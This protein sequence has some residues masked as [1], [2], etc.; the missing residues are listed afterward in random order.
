MLD[1]CAAVLV[2]VA[3]ACPSATADALT[4]EHSAVGCVVAEKFPHFEARFNPAHAVA[5]AKVLF[6]PDQ[7][8][9]WYA[10]AMRPDGPVFRGVLPKPKKSLATFR[11]YIEVTDTAAGSPAP[12]PPSPARGATA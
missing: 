1:R 8:A 6:Q 3:V 12:S 7:A 5:K 11:Y 2:L 4:I 9:H 10:V